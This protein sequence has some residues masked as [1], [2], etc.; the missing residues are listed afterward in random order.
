M[1]KSIFSYLVSYTPTEG[2]K[3]RE[4][5][6]TQMFAWILENVEGLAD[7]Y[8]NFLC[9]KASI[10]YERNKA[11]IT[12]STQETVKGVGRIDLLI[13]TGNLAFI[14]EHKVVNGELGEDQ[15]KKYM[16][17]SSKLGP[18]KYYSVLLTFNRSQHTQEADI[19]IIW[20]D[21]YELIEGVLDSYDEKDAFVLKQFLDYLSENRMEKTEPIPLVALQGYWPA[22]KLESQL[23][24]IFR[25]L[26]KV[27]YSILCPGIEKIGTGFKPEYSIESREWGR[28]GIA[29]F[30]K[31]NMGLFAGVILDTEDH[32]LK[33]L[34]K[35]KGPDLVVLL[36]SDYSKVV[37]STE[38]NNYENN[39]KSDKYIRLCDTLRQDSGPF[40]FMPG[41]KESPWRLAVLRRSLYDVLDGKNSKKEQIEAIRDTIVEATNMIINGLG[42][43]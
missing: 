9:E 11:E 37:G 2:R 26:V 15:I 13:K 16:D 34:N 36:E 17:N 28:L 41:I 19:S 32:K 5:Y 4:D 22:L 39:I 30:P 1:S 43:A 42:I 24:N 6:L 21:V 31:W 33:P 25:Q 10:P 27:D 7:E 12:V 14:C 23:E 18:E 40:D 29:M 38:R 35:D 3:P 8:V 20:S